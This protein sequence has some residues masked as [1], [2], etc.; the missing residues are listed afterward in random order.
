MYEYENEMFKTII[1]QI[2]QEMTLKCP[3]TSQL[4]VES[5]QYWR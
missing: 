2:V 5:E 4:L 1:Y 3:M